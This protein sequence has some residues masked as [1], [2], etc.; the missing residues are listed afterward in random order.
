MRF[1][2]RNRF[3]QGV[4]H[5]QQIGTVWDRLLHQDPFLSLQDHSGRS[6][7]HLQNLQNLRH[8]TNRIE[9][10]QCRIFDLAISLG[11]GTQ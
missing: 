10:G 9:V 8:G 11:H 3:R 2:I 6:V 5:S 4:N 7:W 1:G